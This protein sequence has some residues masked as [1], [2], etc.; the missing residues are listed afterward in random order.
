MNELRKRGNKTP[1]PSPAP[2]PTPSPMPAE[3]DLALQAFQSAMD[4]AVT[5][6]AKREDSKTERAL[7]LAKKEIEVAVIEA[8]TRRE[9]ASDKNIHQ[10]R[11]LLIQ[12]IGD[13][14]VNNA[15]ALT[16]EIM[17]AANFLLQILREE[18]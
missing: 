15:Q 7:I 6:A 17:S 10:R 9:I 5:I 12:K 3:V 18:R 2:L 8:N 4:T 14:L 13:L 16:P 11:M 1:V